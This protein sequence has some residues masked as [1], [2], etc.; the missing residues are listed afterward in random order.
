MTKN[1]FTNLHR[2]PFI[3]T[4]RNFIIG[5]SL[6]LKDRLLLKEMRPKS[7]TFHERFLGE[8]PLMK[9]IKT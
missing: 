2:N 9:K 5:A 6:P 1:Y 8:M 4:L 3:D 7:H